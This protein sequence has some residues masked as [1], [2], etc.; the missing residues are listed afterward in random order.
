M[1]L[2]LD[3]RNMIVEL[4]RIV[5]VPWYRYDNTGNLSQWASKYDRNFYLCQICYP[6]VNETDIPRLHELSSINC[7]QIPLHCIIYLLD[8]CYANYDLFC[9]CVKHE[10]VC[11]TCLNLGNDHNYT[12]WSRWRLRYSTDLATGFQF[13][14]K[15]TTNIAEYPI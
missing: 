5:I 14:T 12:R 15:S 9:F 2:M 3:P 4:P 1:I 6:I 11:C 7:V 10:L 13:G 8:R